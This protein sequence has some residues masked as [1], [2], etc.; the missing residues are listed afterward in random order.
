MRRDENLTLPP[1]AARHLQELEVVLA[2]AQRQ[3]VA[4]LRAGRFS[5]GRKS[6]LRPVSARGRPRQVL[7][8]RRSKLLE[9]QS[10]LLGR[11]LKVILGP[12]NQHEV[13]QNLGIWELDLIQL[14]F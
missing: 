12:A 5:R 8:N 14:L 7:G 2:V 4:G 1:D 9:S 3:G 10:E 13:A 6:A 11:T